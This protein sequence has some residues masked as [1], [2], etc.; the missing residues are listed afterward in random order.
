M[1]G[2]R[3]ERGERRE[4]GEKGR[5]PGFP[6]F[7]AGLQPHGLAGVAPYLKIGGE[8]VWGRGAGQSAAALPPRD[9]RRPL[10]SSERGGGIVRP[11]CNTP[12]M[13]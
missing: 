9:S 8:R 1:S 2:E 5:F 13:H 3:G 10:G 4:R 6:A 11:G 7:P 12:N